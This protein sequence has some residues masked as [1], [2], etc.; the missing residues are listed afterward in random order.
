MEN[1][2][3][4]GNL[5]DIEYINALKNMLNGYRKDGI[6]RIMDFHNLDAIICPS[7]SPAWKTD[8]I[9]GDNFRISSSEFAALSGYPN[10]TIPMG[11]IRSSLWPTKSPTQ[12]QTKNSMAVLKF[13]LACPNL[14]Q[15]RCDFQEVL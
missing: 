8:L 14:F 4:K 10:I 2:H 12:A 3:K 6:D 1:A 13:Y 7:G 11:F 15:V 5:N 9:N